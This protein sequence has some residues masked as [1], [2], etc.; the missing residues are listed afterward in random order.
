MRIEKEF[1]L[2]AGALTRTSKQPQGTGAEPTDSNS[3][4]ASGGEGRGSGSTNDATAD[5]T[6]DAEEKTA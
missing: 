3:D 5:D 2:P 6:A 4:S 1:K